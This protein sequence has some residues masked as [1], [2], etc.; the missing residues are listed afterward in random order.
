MQ[1]NIAKL[2]HVKLAGVRQM[3]IAKV[4]AQTLLARVT[5]ITNR[6]STDARK[7]LERLSSDELIELVTMSPE[8][9][10]QDIDSLW[11]EYRYGERPSLYIYLTKPRGDQYKTPGDLIADANGALPADEAADA[12]LVRNI[13]FLD[14]EDLGRN[15]IELRFRYEYRIDYIDPENERGAYLYE[16]RYSFCWLS[17]GDHFLVLHAAPEG[18]RGAVQHAIQALYGLITMKGLLHRALIERLFPRD[19]RR[20]VSLFNPTPAANQ[21]QRVTLSD[22]EHGVPEVPP[23]YRDYDIPS[24]R[25]KED[26]E[27]GDR[28]VTSILGINSR[29]SKIYLS[30]P[31]RA[32]LLR[33]WGLRLL[34]RLIPN[35]RAT[36]EVIAAIATPVLGD[37]VA[38]LLR[39]YP[40]NQRPAIR[41]LVQVVATT[42][43]SGLNVSRHELPL[44]DLLRVMDTTLHNR[45]MP[46]CPTC[47]EQATVLCPQ[48]QSPLTARIREEGI[49]IVCLLNGHLF[50]PGAVDVNCVEGHPV[51]TPNLIEMLV[52]Y[53]S[54]DLN[55]TIGQV[56]FSHFPELRYNALEDSFFL[57]ADTIT[58]LTGGRRVVI[59]PTD[60]DEFSTLPL[61]PDE[62]RELIEVVRQLKEKCSFSTHENCLRCSTQPTIPCLVKLFAG[63]GGFV[64]HPHF[65]AEFGDVHCRVTIDG[66]QVTMQGVAKSRRKANITASSPVGRELFQQA[67]SALQDN[68]VDMLALVA[69]AKFDDQ[70]ASHLIFFGRTVGKRIS[71]WNEQ[72]LA[73]LLMRRRESGFQVITERESLRQR[74]GLLR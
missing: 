22:D 62:P 35:L 17:L 60:I 42:L 69:P 4:T 3:L 58:L 31:I 55:Q 56:L 65:G 40:S 72:A 25:Y 48:C 6:E 9:S 46:F 10:E 57:R 47:G 28:P 41:S 30:K 71:F 13:R 33:R 44:T 66:Q 38:G 74:L 63:E 37:R 23:E 18:V 32:T 53:P 11:E 14:F 15:V 39:Q 21:Y 43:A 70:L 19:R 1:P 54:Q 12:P 73:R 7:A 45:L 5:A 36:E 61:L 20:R 52:V 8:V 68:R 67:M 49:D 27:F 26:I 51:P 24:S 50:P 29:E 2:R 64:P 16:L 59:Q 34:D